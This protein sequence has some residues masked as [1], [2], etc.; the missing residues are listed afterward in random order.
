MIATYN[1]KNY[2]LECLNSIK[3]QTYKNLE[4]IISDDCSKDETQKIIKNFIKQNRNLNI[5]FFI[6]KKNLNI[7]KNFNFLFNKSKGKYRVSIKNINS[8]P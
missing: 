5:K 2:I 4:I 1:H 8:E 3:S 6:Q 7:S